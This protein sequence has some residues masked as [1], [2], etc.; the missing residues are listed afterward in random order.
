M[1]ALRVVK[2][3]ISAGRFV[4]RFSSESKRM[5]VSGAVR[6]RARPTISCSSLL[7]KVPVCIYSNPSS[8]TDV[9][10]NINSHNAASCGRAFHLIGSVSNDSVGAEMSAAGLGMALYI[11]VGVGEMGTALDGVDLGGGRTNSA[12]GGSGQLSC[13]TGDGEYAGVGSVLERM[14]SCGV[15]SLG[16]RGKRLRGPIGDCAGLFIVFVGERDILD[17]AGSVLILTD[18][19][20]VMNQATK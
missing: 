1:L 16:D 4:S 20:K 5:K 2:R 13:R 17:E 12:M 9:K 19:G 11:G 6:R 10:G 8:K 7:S 3:S 15:V 18:C 14:D